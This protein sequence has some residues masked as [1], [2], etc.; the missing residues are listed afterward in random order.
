MVR[1]S[2]ER[3]TFP[4][5]IIAPSNYDEQGYVLQW[6]VPLVPSLALGCIYSLVRDAGARRVLGPDVDVAIEAYD[7]VRTVVPVRRLLRR[8][9]RAGRGVVLLA[10]VQTCQFPRAVV[11]ARAFRLAGIPVVMGGPHVTGCFAVSAESPPDLAGAQE[12][13]ISFFVGEAEGRMA[14]LLQDAARG[15]LKSVYNYAQDRPDL[16]GQ[17]LPLLP[18][19]M[20]RVHYVPFD[21]GRGC[22]FGC[23]FCSEPALQGHRSRFRAADDVE[24]IV[25]HYLG[26]GVSRFF[27]ADDNLSRNANWEAIV[28]RLAAIREREGRN[29]RLIVQ[30]DALSHAIPRFI[31]KLARA[32]CNR[33]FLGIESIRQENLDAARKTHNLIAGYRRLL[34]SWR[35]RGV[36]TMVGYIIGFPGD[37]LETILHDIRRIQEELPVDILSISILTPAVGSPHDARLRGQGVSR[38]PDLSRYDGEHVTASTLGMTAAELEDAAEQAWRAYY[39]PE[40]VERLFRR[41]VAS[42]LSASRLRELI[43]AFHGAR[44]FLG[45]HFYHAGF[46]RRKRRATRRPGFPREYP[47]VFHARRVWEEW[48]TYASVAAYALRLTALQRRI[49][50]D[51]DAAQYTDAAIAESGV[52]EVRVRHLVHDEE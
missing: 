1:G 50:K 19:G 29:I 12:I 16:Q 49:E 5:A 15:A 44:Q 46:L 20:G 13:G 4:V 24:R 43:V 36:I 32:G 21:A 33:V 6:R 3:R 42:G 28:D 38:D 18:P 11:L 51:P 17:V 35:S 26:I 27:I 23:D 7:E 39:T 9:R 22:P 30:A 25:R 45:I 40:H 34:Q 2:A 48:S 41:A 37:T 52:G 10:G 14:A 31:D 47:V 8:F